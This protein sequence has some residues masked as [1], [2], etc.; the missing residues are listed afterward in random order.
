MSTDTVDTVDADGIIVAA[1]DDG[2]V[3]A[4]S[5]PVIDG[6]RSAVALAVERGRPLVITGRDGC[7]SAGFDLAVMGGD[8][9]KAASALFVDGA[10]LYR[11]IVEAPVPVVASCTGHALAGGALLLLSADHRIGRSGPYRVGLN[12]VS[13][14]MA[15]PNFAVAMATHRLERRFLTSATLFAEVVP[16][17]RAVAMGFLDEIDDDPL[18]RRLCVG[19]H[20]GPATARGVRHHQA[21][22]PARAPPGSGG[23]GPALTAREG[24]RHP[25]G[26]TPPPRGV[27]ADPVGIDTEVVAEYDLPTGHSLVERTVG[28]GMGSRPRAVGSGLS[29]HARPFA[30]EWD[31]RSWPDGSQAF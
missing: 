14:G 17:D 21:P 9:P 26:I 23:A 16:P 3:N 12:E 27:R 19:H 6:I 18:P 2:K 22:D 5:G 25:Y 29:R 20:A 7:F 8:D 4:L 11:D 30:A 28:H 1:I 24:G 31:M 13:I 10:R 15:L